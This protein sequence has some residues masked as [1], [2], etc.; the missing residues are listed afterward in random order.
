MQIQG[1]LCMS[2]GMASWSVWSSSR[3]M[4][5]MIVRTFE[6]VPSIL[7]VFFSFLIYSKSFFHHRRAGFFWWFYRWF[8]LITCRY[9]PCLPF[10]LFS[11][12][13]VS[14][15]SWGPAVVLMLMLYSDALCQCM[16]MIWWMMRYMK[17]RFDA[18]ALIWWMMSM[19]WWMIRWMLLPMRIH[20][21]WWTM[22][23][24]D[25]T[26]QAEIWCG[27][28]DLMNAV[29][30]IVN[31]TTNDAATWCRFT[32]ADERWQR[33]M[34]WMKLRFDADAL[35]WWMMSMILW[36][37]RRMMLLFDAHAPLLM[38]DANDRYNE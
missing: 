12:L 1:T 8:W 6:C 18:D 15:S 26:N 32:I 10:S 13:N 4:S 27:C 21:C 3:I 14:A 5:G 25:T 17:L 2:N 7:S 38:N 30:D 36:M 29:N 16:R 31:D 24:T 35:F 9:E 11:Y 28:S 19:I 34:R 22:P 23:M 20:H 37:I 33:L